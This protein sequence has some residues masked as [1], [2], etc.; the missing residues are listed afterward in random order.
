MKQDYIILSIILLLSE[1]VNLLK[2]FANNPLNIS[3][4]ELELKER[5]CFVAG[6]GMGHHA[7]DMSI[8]APL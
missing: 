4:L 8:R 7:H 5:P 1:G 3:E 6:R 2:L